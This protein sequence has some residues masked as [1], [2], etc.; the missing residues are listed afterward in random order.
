MNRERTQTV[1]HLLR[2]GICLAFAAY[3]W[4]LN[5]SG[6]LAHYLAPKMAGWIK[7]AALV[8]YLLGVFS[9][10]AASG[11]RKPADSDGCDCGCSHGPSP[12]ALKSGTVYLLF[13]LPLLIGLL[14][15]DALMGSAL[16]GK[17]GIR[18][19]G[20]LHAPLTFSLFSRESGSAPS[21]GSPFQNTLPDNKAVRGGSL[22][23]AAEQRNESEQIVVEESR[24]VDTLTAIN[25]HPAQFAGKTAEIRGFVYHPPG[26]PRNRFVVARFVIDCCSADAVPY[27]MVVESG[28]DL[29]LP[30]DA[31]VSVQGRLET[32]TFRGKTILQ[33]K[34]GTVRRVE[35]PRQP[36]IYP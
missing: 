19:S 18:L 35:P 22:E 26:L 25:R 10:Y 11:L 14:L 21:G 17:K 34:A 1:H 24:F 4:Y 36:Y 2:A 33:I 29:D 30:A 23:A 12:S 27:G 3:I 28:K 16:A 15:P 6:E 32:A 9:V 20:D 8:F 13:L 7:G 31:W 5:R